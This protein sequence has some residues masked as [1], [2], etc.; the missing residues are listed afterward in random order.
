MATI[1]GSN[2]VT[3]GLVLSLDAANRRSYP[4]SGTTWS[5]LSG[6][7]NNAVLTNGSSFNTTNGGNI[8]NDGVDDYVAGP[9]MLVGTSR[10]IEIVYNMN[11]VGS[12]WG[13]LWRSDW[14]ERIFPGV[15]VTIN[16]AGTYYYQYVPVDDTNIQSI[17]YSYSGTSLKA[18]RNGE[19]V[20]TQTMNGEMNTDNYYYNFGYQCSGA[21]CLY[22]PCRIYNIKM[23]N[24]QLSDSE[25]QQN[26]N[27]TKSRYL[28]TF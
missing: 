7:G 25:I 21:S 2:I 1:G 16:A 9:T 3:D 18:Y 28:T 15:I 4:G 13:P 17:S 22:S 24:R 11:S 26:Y 20:N 12:S 5:D 6:N 19:L 14:R 10:T 23:Y 8:N 27:S